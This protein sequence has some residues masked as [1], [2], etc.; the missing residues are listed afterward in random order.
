MKRKQFI[1]NKSK[2]VGLVCCMPAVLSINSCVSMSRISFEHKE[3]ELVVLKSDISGLS[4]VVLDNTK[5][6]TKV[7]G[8]IG[9]PTF[10]INGKHF[11]K[12]YTLEELSKAIELEIAKQSKT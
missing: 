3:N 10:F 11:T 9:T 12:P 1:N 2:E 5:L 4:S 7:P 8:F 6:P